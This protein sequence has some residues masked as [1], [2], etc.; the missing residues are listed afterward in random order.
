MAAQAKAKAEGRP[1]TV[2]RTAVKENLKVRIPRREKG[3][4]RGRTI[5]KGGILTLNVSLLLVSYC[6]LRTNCLQWRP[7]M[8]TGALLLRSH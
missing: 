3:P 1:K 2:A 5:P 8:H 7:R 4:E 6:K